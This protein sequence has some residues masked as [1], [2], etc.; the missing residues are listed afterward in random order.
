[1]GKY[2]T[3]SLSETLVELKSLLKSQTNS[4]NITRVNCLIHLKN[5]KFKTRQEL[6]DYLGCDKRTMERWLAKYK[7]GGLANMLYKPT[8]NSTP[9]VIPVNV[10]QDLKQRV[11]DAEKGF[12]S[13]VQ[14]QQ[15]VNQKYGLD[16]K[17][18]TV[19][20]HLINYHKTKIK[21]PRKSHVKKDIEASEAFLKTTTD[22]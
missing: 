6:S 13:Y 18:N 8:R 16:L 9:H 1:M 22:A 20:Q 3:I 21:S 4:K 2:A 17:Y 7:E 12:S 14:A 11:E 19:R 5:S 15:W 10:Q